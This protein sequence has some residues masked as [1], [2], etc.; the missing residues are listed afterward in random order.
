MTPC[1]ATPSFRSCGTTILPL[2][3][4][5]VHQN[6]GCA[7]VYLRL[8]FCEQVAMLTCDRLL[9]VR[10]IRYTLSVSGVRH[11]TRRQT[12]RAWSDTLPT[13]S[14]MSAFWCAELHLM[15]VFSAFEDCK[16]FYPFCEFAAKVESTAPVFAGG[17]RLLTNAEP[18]QSVRRDL[19]CADRE[20]FAYRRGEHLM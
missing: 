11:P 13:S 20:G 8:M 19:Q 15:L 7:A 6:T 10:L 17:K 14:L 16:T 1:C 12:S 4:R 2:L 3:P 9:T 18:A 5:H